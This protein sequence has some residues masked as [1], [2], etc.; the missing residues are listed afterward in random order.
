MITVLLRLLQVV[1]PKRMAWIS[2]NKFALAESERYLVGD[3]DLNPAGTCQI[4][5]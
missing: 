5:H 1:L 3:L 4:A 2:G